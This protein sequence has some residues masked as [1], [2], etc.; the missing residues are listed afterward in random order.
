M[1]GIGNDFV[2]IDTIRDGALDCDV[3]A[4]SQR[5]CDRSFG[6]GADGIILVEKSG[7]TLQMRM[8]NPDGSESEMCGNGLRTYARLCQERNY[9]TGTFDV[10][11]GAGLLQVECLPDQTVKVNMGKAELEPSKI[12][13]ANTSGANFINQPIGDGLTGT[14]VSMGNPHI[15]IFVDKV[16][17]IDLEHEG[18]K[19]ERMVLFPNRTN[20]HFV[21]IESQDEI[22]QRTWERGAGITLACGTGACAGAVAAF[23][24]QKTGRSVKVNLP[25]GSL[26]IQYEETGEVTMTG[27]ASYVFEGS[28]SALL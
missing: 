14:A 22:T 26:N 19:L 15:V 20:V 4:L 21:Q 8:L 24:N 1:H 25:G 28:S 9:G 16:S 12:G 11:T 17:D 18:P 27:T 3:V 6:V 5:V 23:L 2:L 10:Q 7:E 13:M